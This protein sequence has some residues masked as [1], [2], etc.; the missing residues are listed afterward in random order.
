MTIATTRPETML[1]DTAVAVHP[2]P[3]EALDAAEAELQAETGRRPG[4]GKERTSRS[5][6]ARSSG[7]GET[8]LPQLEQLRDMARDGRMLRL[9]LLDR[10]I[11]LVADPWAKPE[12][13]SGCVKITP[14]HDANDYEVGQRCQLPMINILNPDGTLNANAGPY[15]GQTVPKARKRVVADL[16]RQGCWAKSKTAKSIWRIP[17]AARR[18]SNRTWRTSGSCKMDEL[19]ESAMDAVRD[20]RVRDRPVPLRQRIPRLAVGE[21]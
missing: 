21:T 12:L 13:G 5:A 6:R 10:E 17:I 19:A 8:M 14:A 7:G 2:D 11:P 4:Q 16:E 3:A 1:G 18:R 20:G 9:P 15:E